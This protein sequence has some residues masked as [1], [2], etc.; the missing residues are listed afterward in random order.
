MLAHLDRDLGDIV[1]GG[2]KPKIIAKKFERVGSVTP[3]G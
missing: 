1:V 3:C 2:R